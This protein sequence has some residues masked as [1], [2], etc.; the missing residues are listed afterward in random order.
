MA[1]DTSAL[2][3]L[4]GKHLLLTGATGF[5]GKQFLATVLRECSGI[6]RITLLVRASKG[7]SAADRLEK[8]V[9]A[10]AIFE[11][12]AAGDK[13]K[14]AALPAELS[15]DRFGL[16]DTSYAHLVEHVDLVG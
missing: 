15:D 14:V 1:R 3:A 16:D 6:S 12:L 11:G 4:N 2:H 13:A 8:D 7:K 5:L 10:A 9:F